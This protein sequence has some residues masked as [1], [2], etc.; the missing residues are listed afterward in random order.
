MT[1]QLV[2]H[3]QFDSQIKTECYFSDSDKTGPRNR[4]KSTKLDDDE[5]IKLY[6]AETRPKK[7]HQ[8][9]NPIY[10]FILKFILN[11]IKFYL[12]FKNYLKYLY[13]IVHLAI[14]RWT[15]TDTYY[16]FK[17]LKLLNVQIPKHVC[18]VCN[19]ELDNWATIKL[20]CTIIDCLSIYE[21][22]TITFYQFGS[23]S[24]KVKQHIN[25]KYFVKDKNNNFGAKK[26]ANINFLSSESGGNYAVVNAC[27]SIASKIMNNQIE[28]GEVNQDL[29]NS[30]VIGIKKKI[31]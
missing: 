28:L 14:N 16:Y 21:V 13:Y 27:K 29:V 31:Y 22:E 18:V 7:Q 4:K 20:Y 11:L 17:Q 1:I 6:E 10:L 30:Q 12:L 26:N 15:H 8:N 9:N 3:G 2:Q 24:S 5:Y 23:T 19:E 25:D